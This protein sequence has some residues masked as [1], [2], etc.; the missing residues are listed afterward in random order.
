MGITMFGEIAKQLKLS[1]KKLALD[2]CTRWNATYYML[3]AALEFKD[4]FPRYQQRDVLYTSFPS[5]EEWKKVK[6]ICSFLKEF[7]ELTKLV[8]GSE[9]P[10][11]NL[12][13]PELVI[14]RKLLQ[15]ESQEIFMQE[16]LRNMNKKFDKY[17]ASCNLLLCMAVIL[18]S[19]NKMKVIRWCAKDTYSE[20]DGV[21]LVTTVRETLRN[22]YNE[23][24][25]DLKSTDDEN[26][27]EVQVEECSSSVL[28]ESQLK[29]RSLIENYMSD[30]DCVTEN[31][32][33]DLDLEE[34]IVKWKEPIKFDAIVWWKMNSSKFG[35]LSKMV[36]DVLSI[37]IT[38]VTSESTFSAGGR[39]ID[40]HRAS[41]GVDTVQI[42][43][44]TGD[45][46]RARYEIKKKD[47]DKEI[48]V[49]EVDLA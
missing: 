13:L 18:D 7:E 27:S 46:L 35:I 21:V 23:Y 1:S 49:K 26:L 10:T 2:C 9:C 29:S 16:M 37:P 8:L 17:W 39:V 24:V 3:S 25:V 41:L 4:V 19:R 38:T 14:I 22:L 12:F 5:E 30:D 34:P 33:L 40:P 11:A 47:R 42:L 45:W 31:F 15:E 36:C 48:S 44:C 28:K 43:L 32:E 6:L 20:V